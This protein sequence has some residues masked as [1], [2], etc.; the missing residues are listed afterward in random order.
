QRRELVDLQRRQ[1][2]SDEAACLRC[3]AARGSRIVQCAKGEARLWSFAGELLGL[4]GAEPCVRAIDYVFRWRDLAEGIGARGGYSRRK[5]D[6]Q[7]LRDLRRATA[8]RA[9]VCQ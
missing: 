6:G 1:R 3:D 7:F 4:A 5:S 2:R 8:V 9:C